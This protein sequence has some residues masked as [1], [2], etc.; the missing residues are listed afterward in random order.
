MNKKAFLGTVFAILVIVAMAV[1]LFIFF[2]RFNAY[3]KG[4]TF[5]SIS[6]G[7]YKKDADDLDLML[8]SF[9]R[10][11]ETDQKFTNMD[12]IRLKDQDFIEQKAKNTFE[13][14]CYG[15]SFCGWSFEAK[16]F[17]IKIGTIPENH[18]GILDVRKAII[19]VPVTE[20]ERIKEGEIKLAVYTKK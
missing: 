20:G 9:L 8:L 14:L 10:T 3:D 17:E 7:D 6:D 16:D 4:I 12:H 13:R 11:K 1:G 2:Q 19:K 5:E 18:L 15:K